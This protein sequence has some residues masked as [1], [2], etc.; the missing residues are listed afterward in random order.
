[1]K[2]GDIPERLGL[3]RD[4]L[5][6]YE[7]IGLLKADRTNSGIREYSDADINRLKL[8]ICFKESCIP[9]VDIRA[10]LALVDEG[11]GMKINGWRFF[12]V[13]KLGWRIAS[14]RFN[15]RWKCSTLRSPF[16]K[17]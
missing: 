1:M 13:P 4:T 17:K 2:I 5:R 9:L 8:I 14:R 12:F 3:S 11:P 7:K 15:A 6:F 16:E 10:Y